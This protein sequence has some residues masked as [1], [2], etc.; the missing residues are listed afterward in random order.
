M[1]I[2]TPFEVQRELQSQVHFMTDLQVLTVLNNPQHV[3]Q[4]FGELWVKA[5][6]LCRAL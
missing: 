5:I 3:K 2:K 4:R 1:C 6:S